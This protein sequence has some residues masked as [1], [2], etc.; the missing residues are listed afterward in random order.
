MP[1][2]ASSVP[3]QRV[4]V[5]D[6]NEVS[7]E[8]MA[9]MMGS[10]GWDVML[11]K[12]GQAG[13]DLIASEA[14]QGVFPFQ[15]V[16]VDWQMPGLDGWETLKRVRALHQTMTGP[17]PRLIM[18]SATSRDDVSQR[19]PAEQSQLNAFL[20]KPVTAS[21]LFNAALQLPAGNEAAL[22]TPRS[23]QRQLAGMRVL[24]VEDNAIN[25][26]VAEELL[27]FEGALVSIAADGRQGVNAVA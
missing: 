5:I 7:R 26:Q 21:M 20:L 16:Y 10:F 11:A 25:Q 23:S 13:L 3:A 27:S 17:A 19:T 2:A 4:L 1:K 22:R 24:V 12:D 6:D 8:L 18:L 14:N 15:C 9:R